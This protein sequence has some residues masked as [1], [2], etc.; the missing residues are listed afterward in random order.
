MTTKKN[1]FR[2]YLN[3]KLDC[4]EYMP[5]RL[6]EMADPRVDGGDHQVVDA[7]DACV[8]RI[9]ASRDR[10]E[11]IV[12]SLNAAWKAGAAIAR[13]DAIN[14][15]PACFN[16]EINSLCGMLLRPGLVELSKEK[17]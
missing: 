14:D 7:M 12:D 5:L 10:A 13:I 17:P 9:G 15:N 3:S 2:E 8:F 1:P 11:E 4:G 6:V 16:E